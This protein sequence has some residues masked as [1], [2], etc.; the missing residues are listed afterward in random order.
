MIS[1]K[2]IKDYGFKTLNDYYEY[3]VESKING[4]RSSVVELIDALSKIQAVEFIQ[5]MKR[6]GVQNLSIRQE[7]E[8]LTLKSLKK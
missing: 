8:V 6:E 7:L 3:I 4:N 5:W 1:R 2:T